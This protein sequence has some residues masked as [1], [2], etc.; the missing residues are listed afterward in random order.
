M[1]EQSLSA[2]EFPGLIRVVQ[3]YAVAPLGRDFLGALAPSS[4]LSQIQAKFQQIREWQELENREGASPL[5]DFSNLAPWLQKVTVRGSLLP[6]EAF[7]EILQV[8]RQAGLL[9]TY[10]KSNETLTPSLV[11]LSGG[12]KD[13]SRLKEA[14]QQCISPHHFILDQASPGLAGVRREL[15]ETRER[16]NREIK[17]NF[18]KP[19]FQGAL[20]NPIIS[21]RHGRY[22]IPL[23]ADH[24]G[25]IPGII[26]DQSQTKATLYLEPLAIVE[27]NNALNLLHNREKR[28]EELVLR[29]LTDLVRDALEDIRQ[30]LATLAEADAIQAKVLFARDFRAREPIWRSRGGLDFREARHPLL[31]QRQREE[32]GTPEVVP[33]DLT[34]TPEKRWIIISGANAGGK[35]VALKT[36]GLLTLMVQ[37]G[38]PIPVAEGSEF[39]PFDHVFADIGDPQD[40]QQS[41]STFSAHLKK[42]LGMLNTMPGRDL[43]LLDELGTATDPTEG[44]ALALALLQVF[45]QRG[46]YG[47]AT[48]HIPLL[49]GFAQRTEG[50]EN[51]AVVFNEQTRRPTY[52]LAYGVVGASNALKI[53]RELGLSPEILAQAERYLDQDELRAYR[54]LGEVEAAQQELAR[55]ES[56]LAARTRELEAENRKL[57]EEHRKLADE[58]QRLETEVKKEAMVAIKKADEQ[59]KHIVKLLQSG[60]ESWGRLRQEFSQRQADLLKKLTPAPAITPPPAAEYEPGQKVFLPAL[61]LTGEILAKDDRDHLQVQVRHMKIRI[62][63][64]EVRPAEAAGPPKKGATTSLVCLPPRELVQNL[65]IIGLRVDEALPLVDRLIDQAL[66]N[67]AGHVDIIHGVGTGRLKKAV[68]EHLK[69]HGSVKELHADANPGVT[70]V[71]LKD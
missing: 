4:D 7:N 44:G 36:M 51:V 59:F 50:F 63:P 42:A 47:A 33:I 67:G 28:E 26:H 34:L 17:Q 35:T 64:E 71:D 65:N 1:A 62:S 16:V 57:A 11:A 10:L 69:R 25:A 53:A 23:K 45:Y 21:Q 61:G 48:T 24:R 18:F 27:H 22:V 54:L 39:C 41:L 29:R 20:Q 12:L 14:I 5:D 37:S 32:P 3:Q 8:L 46:A 13:L 43:I 30:T 66:L 52:R 40:L 6:P 2:L 49:K 9:K 31:I 60:G 55:Q 15:T 19:E 56:E 68:W 70:V 58:R 38:I